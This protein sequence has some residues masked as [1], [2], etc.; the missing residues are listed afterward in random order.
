M[1]LAYYQMG[2]HWPCKHESAL[3][4][5]LHQVWQKD[6]YASRK[7]EADLVIVVHMKVRHRGA[8]ALVI[9]YGAIRPM[10]A[11]LQIF[12]IGVHACV[13]S[14]WWLYFTTVLNDFQG[15]VGF[16]YKNKEKNERFANHVNDFILL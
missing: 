12:K 5:V 2:G 13:L 11:V 3:G 14:V 16:Y 1:W 7:Y 9:I 6:L 4:R 15:V 10:G 8:V